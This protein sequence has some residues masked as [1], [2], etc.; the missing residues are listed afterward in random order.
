VFCLAHAA[1]RFK[2]VHPVLEERGEQGK[3][4]GFYEIA[5]VLAILQ[6]IISPNGQFCHKM[7]LYVKNISQFYKR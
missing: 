7:S 2:R 6:P 4:N 3:I 1:R 5:T